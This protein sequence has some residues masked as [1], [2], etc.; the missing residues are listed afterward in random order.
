MLGFGNGT[1]SI[2]SPGLLGL[3]LV[4]GCAFG[5]DSPASG[6]FA[7]HNF[8]GAFAASQTTESRVYPGRQGPWGELDYTR[9]LIA[10]P[11]ESVQVTTAP[12]V[13]ERANWFF[14]RMRRPQV[15][16]L[17]RRAQP[18]PEL[19]EKL[20]TATPITEYPNGTLVQPDRDLVLKLNPAARAVVYAVL[21]RF[22][23]NP[24][25]N[26]PYI[27]HPEHLEEHFEGSGLMPETVAALKA[28]FYSQGRL[29]LFAD[30]DALLSTIDNQEE[31]VKLLRSITRRSTLLVKLRVTAQSNVDAL[32]DYWDYSGR[33]KELKPL[34]ES[35]ERVPEGARI[36]LVHLLPPFARKRIY[37]F[38]PLPDDDGMEARRNCHW[39]ALNFFN[40]TADDRF[41][42][43][44]VIQQTVMS[45][46]DRV[47]TTPLEMGDLLVL[48]TSGGDTIHSA[49]YLADDIVYTK[50][51][52]G[53]TQP[54]L[55]MHMSDVLD[56]YAASDSPEDPLQL[57]AFR[58]KPQAKQ[59][60]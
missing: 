55:Y 40:D 47:S 3:A 33:P 34:L 51:G 45:S 36:D 21:S 41:C 58:R 56:L 11:E 12:V 17:L 20:L 9:I 32:V 49:I 44:A 26:E 35:L 31:R 29:S 25:Q 10:P 7:V 24:A 8:R 23:E 15:E 5:A 48:S 43:P 18:A 6:N 54:W 14:G 53:P 57:V 50:N 4:C 19:L 60:P 1:R 16:A 42:E 2:R 38:P 39:S 27:F 13:F 30:A 28:L 59:Q 37:T 22:A 46:Y 52:A